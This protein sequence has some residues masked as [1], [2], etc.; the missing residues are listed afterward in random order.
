MTFTDDPEDP[1]TLAEEKQA[2][3]KFAYIPIALSGTEI[4]FEGG[5]GIA[6]QG[7]ATDFALDSYRLTPAMAAGIMTQQW[8]AATAGLGV[9]N[10]DVCAQLSTCAKARP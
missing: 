7:N 5:A 1:A 2:G 10:D 3:G 9:P 4:A 6:I 8:T